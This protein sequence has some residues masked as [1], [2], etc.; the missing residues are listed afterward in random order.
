MSDFLSPEFWTQRYKDNQIGWD[1]G[2]ISPPI[3]EYVDQLN[4][5]ELEILIPGCGLGH[6]GEYLF[7]NG[8]KNVHLLDFSIDPLVHFKD[9]NP[10]FPE[11]H[12]HVGDFFKHQ[13]VYDL[14]I[15][16]TLF[17]AIDP[18]LR[19]DYAEKAAKLLKPG[20]KL[21]G[22]LFNRDF[23]GGPPF[24]GNKQEYYTYFSKYFSTVEM[25]ECKNSIAPRMGSELF[26]K[27]IK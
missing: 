7:K 5:K 1:L 11:T 16:Q 9:R 14:I 17:C 19:N 22:V 24:G 21:V 13:G 3:K 15:E 10:S 27:L 12:L 20:G 6:E 18:V 8:F 26:I 4:N 2:Q 23:E 25:N